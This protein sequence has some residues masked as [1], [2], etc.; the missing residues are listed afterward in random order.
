LGS[1]V[2]IPSKNLGMPWSRVKANSVQPGMLL[3]EM[4][5]RRYKAPS[6]AALFNEAM[7]Q[8][9]FESSGHTYSELIG[10]AEAHKP[11]PRFPLN[12][13]VQA[14]VAI[15]LSRVKAD[16]VVAELAGSDPSL[17]KEAIA[18]TAHLDHLGTG[19]PDHGDGIYHGAMDDASGVASVLEVAHA[20]HDSA[21]RPRRS[22]LFIAVSGEEKGLLGS[23]YFAAHPTRHAGAIVADIN[24][25]MFLPLFPLKRLVAFGGEESSLGDDSRRIAPALGVEIVPDPVPDQLIFVRSD[26][27]SFVRKGIPSLMLA[28]SPRPGTQEVQV[29]QNWWSDHYHAQ[30]DD[31]NQPVDLAAADAFDAFLLR[32]IT[33]VA[34]APARPLWH[35]KS[36]FARFAEAPLP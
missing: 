6:F 24:M 14:N 25:D 8:K 32:L 34:D 22:I 15:E 17:S 35:K 33:N 23:R 11:L 31:L 5:L 26:Q 10:L 20:M 21:V 9:L 16:N 18:L 29:F 30:A 36:F 12:A 3:G 7:A 2:F 4:A 1:I 19:K 27:Y 13:R 28:F